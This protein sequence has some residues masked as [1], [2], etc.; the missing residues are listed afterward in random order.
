MSVI[1]QEPHKSFSNNQ[2][3]EPDGNLV[4]LN[5]LRGLYLGTPNQKNKV[6]HHTKRFLVGLREYAEY[7]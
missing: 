5:K 6:S 2:D 7:T 1:S 4:E 3:K